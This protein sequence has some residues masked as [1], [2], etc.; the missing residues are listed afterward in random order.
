MVGSVAVGPNTRGRISFSADNGA[1]LG[2][3]GR[4]RFRVRSETLESSG[5]IDNKC[6]DPNAD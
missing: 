5:Q 1:C 2:K 4:S 3:S 6:L